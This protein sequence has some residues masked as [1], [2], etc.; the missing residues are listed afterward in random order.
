MIHDTCGFSGEVVFDRGELL[1]LEVLGHIIPDSDG[2]RIAHWRG[3]ERAES[4]LFEGYDTGGVYGRAADGTVARFS[5]LD[6]EFAVERLC[7]A[8]D[9]SSDIAL[10]KDGA[11]ALHTPGAVS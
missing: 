10:G 8:F 9:G 7:Y 5:G 4:T 11:F 6:V 2:I 1:E 3:G